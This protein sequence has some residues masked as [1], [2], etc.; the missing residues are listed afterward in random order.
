MH[1][2]SGEETQSGQA[3]QQS[4]QSPPQQSTQS[5]PEQSY[6]QPPPQH[7]YREPGIGDIFSRNDTK[8]ELKFGIALYAVVGFGV[9]VIMLL[10]EVLGS[11]TT[12]FPLVLVWEMSAAIA[13]IMTVFITQEQSSVLD[14]VPNKLT[15]ATAAVTA[16]VGTLALLF[17]SWLFQELTIETVGF[18]DVIGSWIAV[19]V[20]VVIIA[21]GTVAI[22]RNV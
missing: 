17:V 6:Q 10:D 14:D 12:L 7:Q 19:L 1:V 5:P 13:V 2:M 8:Y 18:G 16:A 15:Y 11:Q 20:G 3:H 9:G 22:A 4:A 21:V